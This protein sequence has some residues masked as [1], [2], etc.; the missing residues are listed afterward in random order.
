MRGL[1]GSEQQAEMLCDFWLSH[2]EEAREFDH[3][4]LVLGK[5]P[6][7]NH[8]PKIDVRLSK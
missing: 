8:G 6:K 5:L 3:L 4:A 1:D 7:L 2:R